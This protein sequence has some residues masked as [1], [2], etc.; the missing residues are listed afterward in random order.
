MWPLDSNERTKFRVA[1][2]SSV[3]KYTTIAGPI[4]DTS[5]EWSSKRSNR[6]VV[7]FKNSL[8]PKGQFV[9][10]VPGTQQWYG[11]VTFNRAD[12]RK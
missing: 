6:Y 4:T 9:F 12:G 11:G 1:S 5:T 7:T 10:R 8:P 3:N 2:L